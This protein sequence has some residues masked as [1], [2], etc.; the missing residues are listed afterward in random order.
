[1]KSGTKRQSESQN[2]GKLP[3]SC[4]GPLSDIRPAVFTVRPFASYSGGM[5]S[6][7][8]TIIGTFAQGPHRKSAHR[9]GY[10]ICSKCSMTRA[11]PSPCRIQSFAEI[12]QGIVAKFVSYPQVT[13][14][15]RDPNSIPR[16]LSTLLRSLYG[17]SPIEARIADL[18]LRGFE[19]RE[20]G[21][22]ER[23]ENASLVHELYSWN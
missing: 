20:A 18:L 13:P 21:L 14:P 11:F 2:C 6:G 15:P 1:V 12:T 22:S 4:W 16:S 3:P 23:P 9:S 17:L 5:E 7:C 8:K 10:S 19:V